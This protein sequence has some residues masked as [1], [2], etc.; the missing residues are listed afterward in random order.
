MARTGT[1]AVLVRASGQ[2]LNVSLLEFGSKMDLVLTRNVKTEKYV[3]VR[4]VNVFAPVFLT[5]RFCDAMRLAAGERFYETMKLETLLE[6]VAEHS[7]EK[8]AA[9]FRREAEQT[10]R[11]LPEHAAHQFKAKPQVARSLSRRIV[12]AFSQPAQG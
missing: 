12:A 7:G 4:D 10:R 3:T 8:V 5:R 2:L 6:K 1:E 9:A 11:T